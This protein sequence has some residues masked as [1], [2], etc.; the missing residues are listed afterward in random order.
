M[1]SF[2]IE[3]GH[4]HGV[5]PGNIVGAIANEVAMDSRDIGRI[6]IYDEYSTVDLPT[7]MPKDIFQVLQKVWVSGQQLRISRAEDGAPLALPRRDDAAPRGPKKDRHRDRKN[8]GAP[9]R[10]PK[11]KTPR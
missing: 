1:E 9:K 8:K 3:V 4:I 10:A 6:Q 11:S 7:G 5:Q 2:R